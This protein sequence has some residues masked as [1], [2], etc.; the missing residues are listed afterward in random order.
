MVRRAYLLIDTTDGKQWK[1]VWSLRDM[2]DV[3][4]AD[5]VTGPH[6]VVA[7]VE[8]TDVRAIAQVA[9]VDVA[10]MDGVACVTTCFAIRAGS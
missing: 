6:K 10:A 8:G 7:V 5:A 3:A 2:P 1:V 9:S 4:W